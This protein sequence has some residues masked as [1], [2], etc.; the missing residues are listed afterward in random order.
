MITVNI[1]RENHKIRAFELSGHAESGPHG[2]DLVCAAVSSVVFGMENAIDTLCGVEL[3]ATMNED[4]GYLHCSVP[5]QISGKTYD[6]MQLLL[7]AMLVALRA[8]ESEGKQYLKI[9]DK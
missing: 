9:I 4:G 2:H 5:K 6:D 1:T 8:I 3:E 7:E